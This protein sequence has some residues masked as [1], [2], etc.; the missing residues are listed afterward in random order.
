MSKRKVQ[1]VRYRK[2]AKEA[3]F[4]PTACSNCGEMLTYKDS[5][6]YVSSSFNEEGFFS[7]EKK[8]GVVEEICTSCAKQKCCKMPIP[9]HPQCDNDDGMIII[10]CDE[11]EKISSQGVE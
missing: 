11:Y 5:G 8:K 3:N 4:K 1:A 7:C 10:G 6:H 9:L 2:N